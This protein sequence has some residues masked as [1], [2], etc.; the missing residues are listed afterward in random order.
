MKADSFPVCC[1]SANFSLVP[2]GALSTL[3]GSKIPFITSVL[4]KLYDRLV[5]ARLGR[6]FEGNCVLFLPPK[7]HAFRKSLGTCDDLLN[8]SNIL[9]T[10]LDWVQNTF[11]EDFDRLNHLG[12]MHKLR[13]VGLA[14]SVFSVVE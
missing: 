12:L 1:W 6:L 10:V 7:Q 14:E 11:S 13:S 4:P 5:A 2:E 8:E 3:H 9:F